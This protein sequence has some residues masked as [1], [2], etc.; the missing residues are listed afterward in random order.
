[1]PYGN[2]DTVQR[3]AVSNCV[4]CWQ[5]SYLPER[6]RSI[7]AVQYSNDFKWLRQSAGIAQLGEFYN[8]RGKRAI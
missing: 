6:Y 5:K 3:I 2:T 4:Y 8:D 7:F 1:M